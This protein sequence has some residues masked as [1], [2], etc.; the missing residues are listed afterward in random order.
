[1]SAAN[2]V[3]GPTAKVT[4]N[5]TTFAVLDGSVRH[6]ADVPETTDSQ[7]APYKRFKDGGLEH[8]EVSLTAHVATDVS[9]H[10]APL[11]ITAGDSIA[12]AIYPKGLT[13]TAY[14]ISS[15]VVENFESS[16]RV[17]GSEPQTFRISGRSNGSFTLP[18]N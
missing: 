7:S 9:P 6:V 2:A 14:E 5:S 8:L 4:I 13:Y 3:L 16:F 11:L 18:T 10:T 1:M 17:G 15:L 12:I